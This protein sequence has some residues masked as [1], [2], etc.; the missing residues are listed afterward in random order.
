MRALKDLVLPAYKPYDPADDPGPI[1]SVI[2][3]LKPSPG[4]VYPEPY[5]L[6]L[7]KY[8]I[9]LVPPEHAEELGHLRS[10]LGLMLYINDDWDAT[11]S[12]L[13]E[14]VGYIEEE[15]GCKV[16]LTEHHADLTYWTASP[17]PADD[18]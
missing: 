14:G 9:V 12:S 5:A 8:L 4:R 11:L 16:R 10:D 17:R 18:A 6:E 13:D 7:Q 2:D 1:P 15:A 3:R